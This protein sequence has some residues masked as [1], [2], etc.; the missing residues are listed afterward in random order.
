[1][2]LTQLKYFKAVADSGTLKRAAE[3]LFVSASALS[4]SISLLEKELGVPLFDREKNRLVLNRQGELFLHYTNQILHTIDSARHG[5]QRSHSPSGH[6]VSYAAATPGIW[7]DVLIDFTKANRKFTIVGQEIDPERIASEIGSPSFTFLLAEENDVT[8]LQRSLLEGELLLEDSPVAVFHKDHPLAR[9]ESVSLAE[10]IGLPLYLPPFGSSLYRR[11][12]GLLDV[13][14]TAAGS[15]LLGL[16][17]CLHDSHSERICY[18]YVSRG[19]GIT[20]TTEK[21]RIAD[22]P[23]VCHV[24]IS[25]ERRPWREYL[26]WPKTLTLDEDERLFRD[27][28]VRYF[29]KD[30]EK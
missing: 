23:D 20:F 29:R 7:T 1:M 24:P 2:E 25:D 6:Y 13:H 16:A 17:S 14:T 21:N 15:G 3:Q 27:F 30:A 18:S 4:S 22:Y 11:F 28:M 10:I 19:I 12:Q 9:R 26:F 5:I 8:P